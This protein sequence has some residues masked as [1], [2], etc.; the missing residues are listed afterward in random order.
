MASS[1]PGGKGIIS[2]CYICGSIRF[3]DD[4]HLD[5]KG[6]AISPETVPLCRRCHRTYHDWGV[7]SFSPDTT[8]RAL[9]VENKRRAI[10]RLPLMTMDE[11]TR[12]SYWYKKW[13]IPRGRKA[14]VRKVSPQ[15]QLF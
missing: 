4:H 15:L 2:L 10:F 9:E 14:K 1:T 7:E 6:G 11:I 5:C 12:S 8:E 3:I 13:R